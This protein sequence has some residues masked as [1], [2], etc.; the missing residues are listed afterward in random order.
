MKKIALLAAA[1]AITGCA[2]GPSKQA[3]LEERSAV[4]LD[5]THHLYGKLD[6]VSGDYRFT[7]FSE[8]PG[9]GEEAWVRLSDL[10]PTWPTEKENCLT[11]LVENTNDQITCKT[12]NEAQ[13]REKSV[14][15]TPKK[16]AAYVTLSALTFGVWSVMPP[17]AVEFNAEAYNE[18][19]TKAKQNLLK[20]EG[21]SEPEYTKLLEQYDQLVKSFQDEYEKIRTAYSRFKP[22][23]N[24]RLNDQSGLY[25]GKADAFKRV[26]SLSH[27]TLPIPANRSPSSSNQLSQLVVTAKT[28][29]DD[30]LGLVAKQSSEVNVTCR[31]DSFNGINYRIS[32]PDSVDQGTEEFVADITIESM[33]YDNVAPKE[34]RLSDQAVDVILANGGITVANKTQHYI[35]VDSIS[36]YYNGRVVSQ[37]LSEEIAPLSSRRV[38]NVSD[39]PIEKQ[40]LAFRDVTK[41]EAQKT[42]VEFGLASKYRVVD[43]NREKTLLSINDYPLYELLED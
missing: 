20:E 8:Q 25:K 1:I 42:L 32:C 39:L 27:N 35:S 36:Y 37:S 23:P 5:I 26:V 21:L 43:L 14:D 19:V 28:S 9:E 17:G 13:F 38:L 30:F 18:A 33:S 12:A 31:N 40:R 22:T 4:Q 29:M 2:S 10:E 16:T 6:S 15:F 3:Q 7:Q 34:L 11:G 41:T 24:I